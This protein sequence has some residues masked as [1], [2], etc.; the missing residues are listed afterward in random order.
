ML[1][2]SDGFLY[3]AGFQIAGWGNTLSTLAGLER[4]R[5]TGA[6]LLTPREVVPTDRGI[7][8]RFEVAL[9]PKLATDPDNYALASW[10]YKRAHTYGSAQYKADGKTGNDY[11]TASSVLL[12][13]DGKSVFVAV[14]G[15]RPV[16][17]LRI[18]WTIAAADGTRMSSN[19]Y[20][21]PYE[22]TKFD[23]EIG[24]AHV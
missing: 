4:V 3:V 16:E 15:L 6:P 1:F 14:P 22:L 19:A 11:L 13:A 24:R 18:G 2:R 21:T 17:Q 5:Y 10:H 9:D 23:P 8:L 12:S 20:T 7:L